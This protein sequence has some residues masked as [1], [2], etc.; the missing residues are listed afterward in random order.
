[1]NPPAPSDKYR[2]QAGLPSS[3]WRAEPDTGI[4]NAVILCEGMKKAAVAF[5]ELVAKG[6]GRFC[7]VSVPSKMPG[8][9]MLDLL[10]DSDPLYIVLDPDAFGGRKP[11]INRLAKMVSCPKRIVK[12]TVK[13]D[14]FFTMHGGTAKD[15]NRFLNMAVRA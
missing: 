8:R 3:I 2:F 13:S 12:L 15:F 10:Q 6:N 9:A 14:D 1:M 5:I 4:K 11:A 7:V